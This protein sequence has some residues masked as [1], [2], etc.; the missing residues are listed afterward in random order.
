MSKVF[1]NIKRPYICLKIMLY[2]QKWWRGIITISMQSTLSVK[3]S[4]KLFKEK[5][6]DL[7]YTVT[8]NSM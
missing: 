7:P 5:F 8:Y 1:C 6:S 2:L 4:L 3:R